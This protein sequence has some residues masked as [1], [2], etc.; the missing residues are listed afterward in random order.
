M[1][2]SADPFAYPNQAMTTF[3]NAGYGDNKDG[4]FYNSFG[5]QHASGSQQQSG[6][7]LM[8]NPS[9]T[10]TSLAGLDATSNDL[11]VQLF[12]P[13]PMCLMQ[14]GPHPPQLDQSEVGL[15]APMQAH[16]TG[17]QNAGAVNLDELFG[18]EGW[19]GGFSDY[20]GGLGGDGGME[21]R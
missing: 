12:G 13:M 20:Q 10:L 8:M 1:F 18:G 5:P 11:D 16:R 14:G 9:S 21:Y 19:V 7:S 15:Q 2:P 17:G 4:L 6:S 3:E